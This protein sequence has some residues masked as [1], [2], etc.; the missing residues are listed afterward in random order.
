VRAT[1]RPGPTSLL[2]DPAGLVLYAGSRTGRPSAEGLALS[3]AD[4]A[5]IECEPSGFDMLRPVTV[6]HRGAGQVAARLARFSRQSHGIGVGGDASGQVACCRGRNG[7]RFHRDGTEIGRR[8]G[9][10]FQGHPGRK[11]RLS[12]ALKRIDMCPPVNPTVKQLT[13]REPSCQAQ[14]DRYTLENTGLRCEFQAGEHL[15]LASLRNHYTGG[16]MLG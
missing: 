9:R 13:S 3:P 8:S 2:E 11:S 10:P 5:R 12:S 16:E 15:T 14:G 7:C 6:E 4:T 1:W